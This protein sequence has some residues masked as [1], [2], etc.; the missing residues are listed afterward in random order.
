MIYG[1]YSHAIVHYISSMLKRLNILVVFFFSFTANAQIVG[2]SAYIKGNFVEFGLNAIGGF[3]GATVDTSLAFPSGY[4]P[5]DS[6]FSLF[7]VYANPQM[8]SWAATGYDGDFYT[9]GSPENGWGFE[10]VDSLGIST[11]RSNNCVGLIDI[12]GN[13]SSYVVTATETK[14]VWNGN[15]LNLSSGHDLDFQIEYLLNH[16]DLF[17][18]TTITVTNNSPQSF[19]E[20]YFYRN[21]DPDNNLELAGGF[22]TMDSIMAQPNP[23]SNKAGVVAIQNVPW[24]SAIAF[25]AYGNNFKVSK[26]GF[27]NRD[28]SDIWNSV[29]T[30]PGYS[31][32]GSSSV[33]DEA[34]SLGYKIANLSIGQ[35]ESFTYYTVFADSLLNEDFFPV[36]LAYTGAGTIILNDSLGDTV[37]A[38]GTMDISVVGFGKNDYDWTWIPNMYLNVDTGL[39]VTCT[40]LDTITYTVIGTP[41]GLLAAQTFTVTVI[42]AVP[43]VLSV[44]TIGYYCNTF[45]LNAVIFSDTNN[46]ANTSSFHS[47]YPFSATDVSHLYMDTL[48]T[49]YDTVYL[50]IT[51]S[52][53]GC[54]VADTIDVIWQDIIFD[55]VVTPSACNANTGT[56]I[57]DFVSDSS[58]YSILWSTGDTLISLDSL[59]IGPISVLVTGDSGCVT[60]QSTAIMQI[61]VFDI[62]NSV[63]D[64]SCMTCPDGS[65]NL[66]NWGFSIW[67]LTFLWNTGDTTQNIGGLL[68]G[69]YFVSVTDGAG[70]VYLDTFMVNYPVSVQAI[71]TALDLKVFPNPFGDNLQVIS[72]EIINSIQI[73]GIDSRV[74]KKMDINA[75]DHTIDT[76]FLSKGIY[77]INIV[78]GDKQKT[79][80]LI[81][82]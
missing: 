47:E 35:T 7:G 5:R 16:N 51:D 60:S 1:L 69:V 31:A 71:N 2:S 55:L 12:P 23:S 29:I 56:A 13:I 30:A 24:K 58:S 78:A 50:M 81:K 74:I 17:Y 63:I 4:H 54:F 59:G 52:T 26:G 27:S 61:S 39:T 44:S 25:I 43:P 76:K 14:V 64:A 46:V 3:E 48:M 79:M 77:V 68:P 18:A 11:T 21:T 42:P 49:P 32:V 22:T 62:V 36:D 40:P 19:P 70:C 33:A 82:N 34:I 67:P 75:T 80:R 38:C 41:L 28:G 10:L 72:S 66:I 15:Y 53:T 37:Y 65:I 9:P 45:D 73:I 6:I 20:F 8:N 57:I